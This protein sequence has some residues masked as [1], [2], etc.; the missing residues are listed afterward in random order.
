MESSYMLALRRIRDPLLV[1]I[2]APIATSAHA[3]IPVLHRSALETKRGSAPQ[4]GDLIAFSH[5]VHCLSSRGE[6]AT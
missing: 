2:A 3:G 1:V 6:I 5:D 4:T